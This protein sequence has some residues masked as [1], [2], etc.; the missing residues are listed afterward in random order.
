MVK[1]SRHALKNSKR[2]VIKVG[3]SSLAHNTGRMNLVKM[4]RLSMMISEL[5]NRGHE[6]ILVSSGSIAAGLSKLNMKERPHVMGIKQALAAVGQCELMNI[7]SKL[8]SAYNQIVAQI[9][10]TKYDVEDEVKRKNIENTF[11]NLLEQHILPIVNENDTVSVDEIHSMDH[12]GDN[13]TLS[14][15]VAQLVHADLLI[16]LSDING[17]YNANPKECP[18][19]ELI[20]TVT[21]ITDEI[22]HYAGGEG[23]KFGTGGMVTKLNAADIATNNGIHMVL[24]NGEDPFVVFNILSGVRVGTMF[25]GKNK[26][27]LNNGK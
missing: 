25:V 14:A 8:F 15:V 5:I 6:V 22:R 4:D 13:D 26:K 3:T 9:L 10:L 11:E 12:F 19:C 27:T 23:T 18:D 16:I 7:Y 24:A 1:Q 17:F 21:E 2:I 20:D